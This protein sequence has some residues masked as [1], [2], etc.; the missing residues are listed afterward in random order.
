MEKLITEFFRVNIN[1]KIKTIGIRRD[2]QNF[3]SNDMNMFLSNQ[4]WI[5]YIEKI[6]KDMFNTNN[7]E[8]I[9]DE[10]HYKPNQNELIIYIEYKNR[11]EV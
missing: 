10:E 9:G 4:L 3:D 8:Y 1:R 5:Q 2:E 11:K 6:I 7:W